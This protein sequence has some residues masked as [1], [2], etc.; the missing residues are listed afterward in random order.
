[1]SFQKM[2]DM[3]NTEESRNYYLNLLYGL[4]YLL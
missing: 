4:Y 3:V 1:M 2:T